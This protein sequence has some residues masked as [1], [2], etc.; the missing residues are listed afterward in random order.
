M[1]LYI[2]HGPYAYAIEFAHDAG[3]KVNTR[4]ESFRR[5]KTQLPVVDCQRK[6]SW[7]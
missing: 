3:K 7:S 4:I 6:W 5:W 2:G 1:N